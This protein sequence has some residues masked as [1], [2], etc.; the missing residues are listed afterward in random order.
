MR[1][2]V[3]SLATPPLAGPPV[4]A[5]PD[6]LF[7]ERSS[8]PICG[9][10]D[11][12]DVYS[13]PYV[14][15]EIETFLRGKYDRLP[16][17]EPFET[18]FRDQQFVV[19]ECRR[20]R[21]YF[22]RFA[23]TP[24]LAAEYYDTWIASHGRPDWRFDE[25]AHRINEALVLTSFLLKH[26]GKR[27]P[28]ELSILDFGVG[29][30]LFALAMRACGCRVAAL[31]LSQAREEE[32]RRN[33]LD[34]V[35]SDEIPGSDFDFINTEQVFEHLPKPQ[36]TAGLLARGLRTGGV[37]KI[38]VP[39]ARWLETGPVVFD[40]KASRYGK[41]SMMFLQPIEHLNYFRRP[42]LN[43]M[44]GDLGCSEVKLSASDELNYAF[45]WKG[46]RNIVKNLARPLVRARF[47]NYLLFSKG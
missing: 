29:R 35:A 44:M 39:Y 18:R 22:Q 37:L 14:G 8:C 43:V 23:P 41:G 2:N 26:T 7:D 17:P 4:P 13:K 9:S 11:V 1:E 47:R 28:A 36:E 20:C 38:S 45:N 6:R 19:C 32:A 3:S 30:G 27:S 12:S 42:S 5:P 10:M 33:G 34:I 21:A 15:S 40:A 24:G 16:R 25:Y 31:D 46:M